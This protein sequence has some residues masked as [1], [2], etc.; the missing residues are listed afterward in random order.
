MLH[1]ISGTAYRTYLVRVK[2]EQQVADFI[3]NP[4]MI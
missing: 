4:L 2:L 1:A 3:L